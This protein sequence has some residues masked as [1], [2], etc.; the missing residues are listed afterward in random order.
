MIRVGDRHE[1]FGTLVGRET[2]QVYG[3]LL[4]DHVTDRVPGNGHR[5]ARASRGTMVDLPPPA[6][7]RNVTND[8]PPGER[9]APSMKSNAPPGPLTVRDRATSLLT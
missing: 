3:A 8:A 5:G 6:V 1:G 2:E 7:E 4:R 9:L